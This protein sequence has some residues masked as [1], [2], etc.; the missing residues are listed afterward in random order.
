MYL[1]LP[2]AEGWVILPCDSVYCRIWFIL[3][4]IGIVNAA[5]PAKSLQNPQR[6]LFQLY[7]QSSD[8]AEVEFTY[9]VFRLYKISTSH[10]WYQ[11][12]WLTR[13][14]KIGDFKQK[15]ET[16]IDELAKS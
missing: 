11:Y 9:H 12:D 4:S 3:V 14:S 10:Y 15:F 2:C 5:R 16:K 1:L 13:S 8:V 6:H 7:L